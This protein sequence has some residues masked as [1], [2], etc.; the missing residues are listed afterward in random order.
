MTHMHDPFLPIEH[1][2]PG[3]PTTPELK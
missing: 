3:I 1:N 2:A